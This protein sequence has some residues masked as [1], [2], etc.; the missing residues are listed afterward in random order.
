V[1]GVLGGR[2]PDATLA[3]LLALRPRRVVCTR[4]DSPRAV[5]AAEVAAAVD[6]AVDVHDG[7]TPEVRTVEPVGEAVRRAVDLLAPDDALLVTG[8]TYVAGE[9]RS[10]L[11]TMGFR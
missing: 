3:P 7:W 11:R 9:A 2:D 10:A 6:R 5:P 8:S 1:V 4:A